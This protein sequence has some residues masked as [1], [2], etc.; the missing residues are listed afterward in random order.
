MQPMAEIIIYRFL[1]TKIGVRFESALLWAGMK[2]L[3]HCKACIQ[4]NTYLLLNR[5][6]LSKFIFY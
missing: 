3:L 4:R 2:V 6:L 1:S 5:K